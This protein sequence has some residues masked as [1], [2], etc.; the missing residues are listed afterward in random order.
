M[1]PFLPMDRL[2]S[3]LSAMFFARRSVYSLLRPGGGRVVWMVPDVQTS[4]TVIRFCVSVPVLS[5]FSCVALPI[6]SHASSLRTRF[7][8]CIILRIANA[9][10]SVM[11]SGKPSGMA[12]TT[13]VTELMRKS[14]T[15]TP[16]QSSC[17]A[18]WIVQ[19]IMEAMKVRMADP[20]PKLPTSTTSSFRRSCSGVSS[21]SCT[22]CLMMAPHWERLPTATAS[23]VPEPSDTVVP[24]SRNGSLSAFFAM[25]MGS[26]VMAD[27]FVLSLEPATNTPSAGSL[28]PAVSVTRSPTTMSFAGTASG[29]PLRSTLTS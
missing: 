19:R 12:T 26:P 28:S 15:S 5:A 11:A 1:R 24:D 16:S 8:S 7:W 27:S 25:S 23:M 6:V 3:L 18:P 2:A 22:S 17:S 21:G 4:M 13:M 14:S 29:W 10:P 20:M 9:R